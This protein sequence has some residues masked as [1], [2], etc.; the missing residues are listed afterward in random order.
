LESRCVIDTIILDNIAFA[1]DQDALKRKL[2][3]REGSGMDDE[4]ARLA[5]EAEAVARP[6]AVYGLGYI[7]SKDE[8]HIVVDGIT[9]A[10]RV[11]R[12]NV[13]DTHR[14]FPYA[15][16]CGAELD[17][18]S[19]AATDVLLSFWADNIKEMALRVATQALHDH[20]QARFGLSSLS[21]MNPGSLPDWPLQEQRP[22]F[23]LLGSPE[24]SI[25]VRLTESLIMIPIKSVSGIYFASQ[26]DFANCQLCPRPKCP[27][28]RAP[29]DAILHAQRYDLR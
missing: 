13:Q 4:L 24:E 14:V 9:L 12:V 10:S 17:E 29:Y 20:L 21:Q 23:T 27:S 15:A 6:K 16:T 28:R 5:A 11:L 25:G 8:D 19:A 22:L 2:R 1:L 7:D 18:W 3:V 26:Q